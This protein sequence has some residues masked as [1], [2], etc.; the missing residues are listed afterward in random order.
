MA[1]SQIYSI[2]ILCSV[3]LTLAF[4]VGTASAEEPPTVAERLEQAQKRRELEARQAVKADSHRVAERLEQARQRRKFEAYR[5]SVLGGIFSRPGVGIAI[6]R[7]TL[8]TD[9]GTS[10]RVT[11]EL[12]ANGSFE[13]RVPTGT[14]PAI[15]SAVGGDV[16]GAHLSRTVYATISGRIDPRTG[17]FSAEQKGMHVQGSV[18]SSGQVSLR[19]LDIIGKDKV[20]RRLLK[21]KSY[22]IANRAHREGPKVEYSSHSM[23]TLT[24]GSM[25]AERVRKR[26]I[27]YRCTT[28]KSK[29]RRLFRLRPVP[30]SPSRVH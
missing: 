15:V 14:R 30:R 22:D 13:L 26:A 21:N 28:S 5:S 20:T 12:R 4:G 19:R 3:V 16:R 27:R 17:R 11:F 18:D 9:A 24:I 7:A 23:G 29:D 6:T 25:P 8:P 1:R 2:R 10:V